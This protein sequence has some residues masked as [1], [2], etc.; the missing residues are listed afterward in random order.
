MDGGRFI[1][2]LFSPIPQTDQLKR[3]IRHKVLEH[4]LEEFERP[5]FNQTALKMLLENV[6]SLTDNT[7]QAVNSLEKI[8]YLIQNTRHDSLGHYL[9]VSLSLDHHHAIDHQIS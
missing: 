8:I 7:A 9:G 6:R 3:D 4:D 5:T 2:V 1:F